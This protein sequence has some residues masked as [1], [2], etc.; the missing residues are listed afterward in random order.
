M[1][2]H[3]IFGLED[4]LVSRLEWHPNCSKQMVL[5]FLVTAFLLKRIDWPALDNMHKRNGM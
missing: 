1:L 4:A 3:E 5:F 2:Q